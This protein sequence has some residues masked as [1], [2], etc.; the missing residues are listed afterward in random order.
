MGKKIIII[1][2]FFLIFG[3][4]SIVNADTDTQATTDPKT[5]PGTSNPVSLPNPINIPPANQSNPIP[6]LLG[7]I[8]S[9]VMGII[10][11]LALVMFIFGGA[12]WMLSGGNQERVTKGKQILIWA[13]LGIVIIFT[14]YAIIRFLLTTLAG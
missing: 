5:P 13:T 8:I 4:A 6:Y 12:T 7:N 11:S 3:F 1:L 14:A 9:Y 10:G 2:F